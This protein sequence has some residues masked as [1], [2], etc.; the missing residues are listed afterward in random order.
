MM[1]TN[2]RSKI[3]YR[4]YISHIKNL[5]YKWLCRTI[6]KLDVKPSTPASGRFSGLNMVKHTASNSLGVVEE[7]KYERLEQ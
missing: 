4:Q 2:V 6:Q 5:H 7:I 3:K 1:V